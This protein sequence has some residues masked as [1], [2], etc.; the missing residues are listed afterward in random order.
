MDRPMSEHDTAPEPRELSDEEHEQ[1]R[2][3][4]REYAEE[5]VAEA[6]APQ[7]DEERLE[8][9]TELGDLD[10]PGGGEPHPSTD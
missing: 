2:R 1:Q 8:G 10:E 6:A 3:E 4:A 5:V 7:P 9:V